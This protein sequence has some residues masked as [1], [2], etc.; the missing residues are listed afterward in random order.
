MR[1][2]STEISRRALLGAV[3]ASPALSVIPAEAGTPGRPA[4]SPSPGG[5]G[6]ELRSSSARRDDEWGAA[7]ARLREA[8]AILDAAR[9]EPDEDAYD[10]LLDSHSSALTALLALPP[11]SPRPRRQARRHRPQSRLGAHRKRRL[12]RASPAG[13]PSSRRGG[14]RLSRSHKDH[15]ATKGPA[16]S[17]APQAIPSPARIQRY[18]MKED[19]APIAATAPSWLRG[20]RGLCANQKAASIKG[21]RRR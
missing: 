17:R 3:C 21:H 18:V 20:L 8:Q 12:P 9:S 2:N 10:R 11:P 15:Q 14:G 4:P 1:R 16:P 5:P 19:S 6:V 7:L 13:C